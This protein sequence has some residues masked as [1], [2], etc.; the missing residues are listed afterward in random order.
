M[1]RTIIK[2][3]DYEYRLLDDDIKRIISLKLLKPNQPRYYKKDLLISFCDGIQIIEYTNS[4]DAQ[5]DY[6]LL[7]QEIEKLQY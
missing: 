5:R 7:K 6:L 1:F 3:H 2:R 4:I